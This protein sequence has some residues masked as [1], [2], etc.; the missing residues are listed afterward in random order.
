MILVLLC[1]A[2]FIGGVLNTIAGGGSFLTMPALMFAGV[3]AVTANAT[4]TVALLPGY[5]TGALSLRGDTSADPEL[6]PLRELVCLAGIGGAIGAFLLTQTNDNLL[7]AVV[8]WMMLA[9]TMLFIV[10]PIWITRRVAARANDADASADQ[11]RW[12]I[13]AGLFTASLYGGYFNGGMGILLLAL[14]TMTSRQSLNAMNRTKNWA[15][16]VLTLIAT[17]VYMAGDAI[18]W[19]YAAPMMLAGAAGGW[20]GG[21]LARIVPAK[22]VRYYVIVIGLSMTAALFWKG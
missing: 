20:A 18:A 11:S 9:A 8:P 17:A 13:R 6:L 22:Q 4:G 3:P 19:A 5:V 14:F 7:R 10:G 21:R 1:C 16:A 15:S 2:A 12:G